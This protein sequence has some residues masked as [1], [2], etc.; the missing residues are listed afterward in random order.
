MRVRF[1]RF[2]SYAEL[3]ETLEAWAA[4]FPSL[5]RF[6]AV[7]QSYEGR[8][9][10]L[11]TVTNAETGPADEKPA[12][13]VHAQIHAMEF[14][15]TTAALHLLD[16]LLHGHGEDERVTH[17]VDT[18]TFYVVPRV[19][20]DGADAGLAD[21]RF[22]RSSVRPY[23]RDE[24]EDGLHRE[25]VDGD[26]RVLFMRMPDRNGSWKAHPD[27]PRLLV[28]RLPDDIEGDFYRVLPEGT[29]RN[30][31]GVTIPIA[32]ALEGLDLN[33]NWPADWA[34][35]AEQQGAGP[36]PTSEPEVRT[37]V[38]AIVDR[39]NITSYVGYHTFSGVHLRPWSGRSDDD[40]PVTDL[41]AFK[42]MGEEATRLT[43]YPAISIFHDFKYH[44]KL[45][46]K[47]GDIDWLYDHLGVYA[48]VTEFWSPQREAGLADYHFIDWIREHS[49]DD[50]LAVLKVA[51]ELGEGYVDW[52]AVRPSAARLRR[53]RRLGSRALLVQPSVV[54]PRAGGRAARR[55]RAVPRT[56]LASSRDPL[57]RVRTGGGQC[58]PPPARAR[59]RGLAADQ[60]LREG[61]RAQGRAP[62]RGRARAARGRDD[63]KR[64]AA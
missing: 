26:G 15:G 29:I 44:P 27:D 12:V 4:E 24:P 8:D 6:E 30:W 35:E 14:T 31:D 21:G 10:W 37:L 13:F 5:F 51:D 2:Y 36:F 48:W 56:R 40:F 46:I 11:C 47:G 57:V 54:A 28:A 59:E 1:D 50:D 38:Q 43:G 60:R 20:P 9:I 22:R 25:D 53:A 45:V 23:P 19:N 63:R 32:P 34:P 7:G 42:L 58:F 16:R 33:R 18:R 62:D 17:A 41:R 55:L 61:A 52:Y 49:A 3:T 64:E 39:K